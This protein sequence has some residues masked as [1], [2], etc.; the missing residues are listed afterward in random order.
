VVADHVVGMG[1]SMD[2]K[3]KVVMDVKAKVVMDVKAKVVVEAV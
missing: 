2:V 1:R 3:A